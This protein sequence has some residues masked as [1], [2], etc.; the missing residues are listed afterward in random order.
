MK[1]FLLS[2]AF[3]APLPA[4]AQSKPGDKLPPANPLPY[5]DAESAAVMAPVNA[6]FTAFDRNDAAGILA[7]TRPEGVL[8]VV[9]EKRDGTRST[10]T[11]NW[12]K[13]ASV[14][15]PGPQKNEERL[16]TPAIE[17]DGDI[18]MVWAPY[19]NY[20]EGKPD[21]CGIDQIDLVREN[22]S[23]KVL[24]ITSSHR[25]SGCMPQ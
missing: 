11:M 8:L 20:L 15:K 16:G 5:E 21:H 24:H 19:V 12:A 25:Y 13:L 18:A 14:I 23:W 4:L 17:I 1:A 10:F 7:N 2:L 6:L 22:G 3:L 9:N